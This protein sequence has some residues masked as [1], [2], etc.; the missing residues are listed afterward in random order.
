MPDWV[1]HIGA[2]YLLCRSIDKEDVSLALIGAVLPDLISRFEV[3]L[4]DIFH[5]YIFDDYSFSS[6][7]T[8]FMLAFLCTAIALFTVR[9]KRSFA[10]LFGF[11]MLH[12]FLDM[13]EVKVP[14]FG[15][16]L[17]FPFYIRPFSFNLFEF[18]GIGYLLTYSLFLLILLTALKKRRRIP[19][20]RWTIKNLK[21][22]LPIILFTLTFPFK[23]ALIFR[24][25]NAGDIHFLINPQNW[26]G[27]KV[28]LHVSR[29]ISSD[30]VVVEENKHQFEIVTD[31]KFREGDWVSVYGTYNKGKITPEIIIREMGT[32]QKSFLSGM[33][34][35][36]LI[37]F[38]LL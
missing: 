29:V 12:L 15:A 28:N 9:V 22:A 30:P 4:I 6:F 31:R 3:V 5:L 8:P 16:F 18:K 14:A 32:Y 23:A 11:S 17:F 19:K 1:I 26:D 38:F 7:H 35:L 37:G 36:F 2:S 20:I 13:L 21:W 25:N 10:V 33:G 24:D 27:K 34:L